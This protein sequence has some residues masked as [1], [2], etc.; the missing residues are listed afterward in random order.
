MRAAVDPLEQPEIDQHAGRALRCPAAGADPAGELAERPGVAAGA[1]AGDQMRRVHGEHRDRRDRASALVS[2][3]G[4][5]DQ[6][7]IGGCD[8]RERLA[9]VSAAHGRRVGELDQP[10]TA[11]PAWAATAVGGGDPARGF[12]RRGREAHGVVVDADAGGQIVE[13]HRVGAGAGA[14][15][16]MARDRR[17][18]RH[19]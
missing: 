15:H 3:I 7:G 17:E 4:G 13:R 10:R 11:E 9:V 8:E 19:A 16:E 5:D 6:C 14:G 18:Q 2:G 1:A 12:E